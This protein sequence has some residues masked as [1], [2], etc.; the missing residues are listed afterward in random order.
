MAGVSQIHLDFNLN[1]DKQFT[2]SEFDTMVVVENKDIALRVLTR[3]MEE[4]EGDLDSPGADS[5]YATF[6][7]L[8]TS[9]A[10]NPWKYHQV[11]L[12]PYT[13]G[14]EEAGLPFLYKVCP[15][16]DSVLVE[17]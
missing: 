6:R 5:H 3:I 8:Y 7:D 1:Q 12:N 15:R 10:K 16:E 4:G 14:Y 9:Y 13:A 2:P 17:R 11:P